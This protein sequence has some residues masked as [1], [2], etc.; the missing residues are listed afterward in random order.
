[1]KT[2]L[3]IFAFLDVISIVLLSPQLYQIITNIHQ[4]PRETLSLIKVAFTIITFVLLFVSAIGLFRISKT[5]LISYYFQFPMR[6][7]I[8]VF[9]FGFLTLI[10]QFISSVLVFEMLFRLV[11]V[12]EFF[13]LFF[14]VRIHRKYFS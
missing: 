2:T 3:R 10:S 6:I 9:S 12:L 13:R 1:M 5:G 4:I 7:V 14:T 11:F 8:W